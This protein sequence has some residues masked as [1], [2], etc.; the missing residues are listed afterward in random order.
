MTGSNVLS[1]LNQGHLI[2]VFETLNADLKGKHMSTNMSLRHKM[3]LFH[4]Y[5]HPK[6][7][8][9]DMFLRL[10]HGSPNQAY[11]ILATK[12]TG[13]LPLICAIYSYN[14]LIVIH[15]INPC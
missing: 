3:D 1:R 12:G 6:P 4:D 10:P 8:P 11:L 9:D 2:K 14:T 5:S 7:F 15:L 13:Y